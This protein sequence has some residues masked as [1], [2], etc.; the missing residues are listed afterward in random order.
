MNFLTSLRT[1]VVSTLLFLICSAFAVSASA[2]N[3]PLWMRYAQISPDGHSIIFTYKGDLFS[4]SSK[5]GLATRLTATSAYEIYPKWS[6]DGTQIAF[7]SDRDGVR[8]I[9]VMPA[10][11]GAARR[12]TYNGMPHE[13]KG[14]TPKGDAVL[15]SADLQLPAASALHPSTFNQLYVASLTGGTPHLFSTRPIQEISFSR[16]GKSY[17]F[18]DNKGY[19]NRWR[20]HH[21]SS[22]TRDIYRFDTNG[23]KAVAL[24]T[25]PGEDLN[26]IFSPDERMVYFLSQRDGGS[27]NVWAMDALKGDAAGANKL[28]NFKD[29]PV[30]FL[31]VADNGTLAYTFDGEIYTQQPKGKPQRLE[32]Q[33]VADFSDQQ[34]TRSVARSGGRS[35]ALSADGK[36]MAFIVQGDVFVSS[37]EHGSTKRITQTPE[38]EEEVSFSPDGKWLV[39]NSYRNG[40]TD[41]YKASLV[42]K[43]E[44]NF[45]NA[46]LIKEELLLPQDPTE[47]HAPRISPD[48]KEIAYLSNRKKIVAYN[49]AD[50]HFRDITDGS[51]QADRDG[52]I[53]FSWS[54]DSK[55]IVMS[56]V[57]RLH[58]PYS[59]IGI[60]SAQ[61]GQVFNVT[62][63]GYFSMLPVWV[64]N[65]EA[66]L[67]MTDKYGMR[68]HASWGSMTDAMLV[69]MNRKAY[70]KYRMTKEQYDLYTASGLD[71]IPAVPRPNKLKDDTT[72][73][74]DI[75]IEFAGME[76]RIVRLTFD[77]SN[78]A[79]HYVDPKGEKLY[80]LSFVEDG[81]NLSVQDLRS[82]ETSLLHRLN[83][84]SVYM[85][86]DWKGE[87]LLLC[88]PSSIKS[89]AL[90][91]GKLSNVSYQA[92]LEIDNFAARTSMFNF[93]VGEVRERFYRKDMHGVDW[94]RLTDHYR[95]FLPHIAN[96]YDFS[97][98]LSEIL[99]ELNV[100]HT[101][102]G[103]AAGNT[104]PSPAALGLLLNYREF[105]DKGIE[106]EEILPGTPFDFFLS[107]VKIGDRILAVNGERITAEKDL[108]RMLLGQKGKPTR[109]TLWSAQSGEE[110]DEVIRPISYREQNNLLYNRWVK[111][112]REEVE[113]LSGGRLGY[114]HISSMSDDSFRRAYSDALGRYNRAE[115]IVIDIRYNGGGRLH[116]DIEVFFSGVPYLMQQVQGEDYC[117]MPSRRWTKPSVMLVCEADYSN[118]H[119]TPWVYQ[120][121]KI[122]KVVGMPVPGTMTSVNW[123]RMQDPRIYFGIP[124]VGYKTEQGNYLEN[125]QLEPD[126]LAPQDY[127]LLDKGEDIQLK[128][129]VEVLLQEIASRPK[130]KF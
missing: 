94:K 106:I 120:T 11:G 22:L 115:G 49:F 111:K 86:P 79:G 110:F 42:A 57:P 107:K 66:I 90:S 78:I 82:K 116:E 28:T 88:S 76:D 36:Q 13:L 44:K 9:Y 92:E 47:K 46:T 17:L 51:G 93:M 6:P 98:M 30:R 69:F 59:D 63:S 83:Q 35:F 41:L 89:L 24:T 58:A 19:E 103:F 99:G 10:K 71:S 84:P 5:G 23:G 48:G 15:F 34:T 117:V 80:Y 65:G 97:E 123:E 31:S 37:V 45:Y 7:M 101:G 1:V 129:A 127:D 122:G 96:E 32:V 70:Q 4:V 3:R 12:I 61:G 91:G 60:V 75:A 54:P 81:Y 102:S 43:D 38:P 112:R 128:R 55:W 56:Y 16:S 119:G 104:A 53:D 125:T 73:N 100:S 62:N 74:K 126:V 8:S 95:K 33:V 26:P 29:H 39:Y 77:S 85:V 113:R 50:K 118:A 67:F 52:D 124:V 68:N 72:K 25:R 20:K 114:V 87:K 108:F 18:E 21:T 27:L 14:F 2:Q 121:R 109:I 130:K 40:K 64:M 105:S